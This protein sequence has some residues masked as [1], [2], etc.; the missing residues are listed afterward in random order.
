MKIIIAGDF[1]PKDRVAERIEHSDYNDLFCPVKEL[2]EKVDYSIVNLE[3]PIVI[4]SSSPIEKCGPNLKCSDKVVDALKIMGFNGVTLANNHFL[5]FGESGVIDTLN[6]LHTN[7]IDSVGGGK[8][9]FEASKILYIERCGQK[10]AIINCCEHEFSIATDSSAG[11]NP[12]NVIHQHYSIQ[13]AKKNADYVIVIIHGGWEHF[14]YP[15]LRMQEAY[16]F[17]I[18]S[19]ADAVINH[20][21]HCFSG[22]EIYNNKPIFYGLGNFCFDW[23]GKRQSKWNEGYIVELELGNKVSFIL[24]PYNQCDKEPKIE[25]LSD[26]TIFDEK[27]KEINDT[28]RDK[29]KLRQ[30]IEDYLEKEFKNYVFCFEPFYNKYTNKLFW[31]GVMPSFIERRRTALIDY[32]GNES[33]YEKVMAAIERTR[34]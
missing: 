21:Q 14:Q 9:L 13:E 34:K 3:C 32:V 11:A 26:N 20:H 23:N 33:H 1:C 17:F 15:S 12:L 2:T 4:R 18:D 24:Y 10:V 16:R 5:D 19:G 31:R 29:E 8:N 28:I 6:V 25:F 7:N 27:I 30:V 22:Y